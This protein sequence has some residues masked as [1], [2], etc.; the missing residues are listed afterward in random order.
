[1]YI[2]YFIAQFSTPFSMASVIEVLLNFPKQSLKLN[3][4]SRPTNIQQQQSLS[5]KILDPQI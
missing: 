4:Y 2:K 1:M 5:Q 3:R